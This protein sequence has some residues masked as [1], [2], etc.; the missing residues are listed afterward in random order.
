MFDIGFSEMIVIAVVALVVIGPERLPKVARTLGHL[1]GR[2]Q[3]YVND[4][5]SDIS[6]E[7]ELE[8]LR[9]LQA[10]VEDAARA[11]ET[12]VN[13]EVS[14]TESE[15]NKVAAEASVSAELQSITAPA[16]AELATEAAPVTESVAVA[17][18][19]A[20]PVVAAA[21]EAIA[22]AVAAPQLELGLEP[23]PAS[24]TTQKQA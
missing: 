16:A 22:P 24:S 20:E 6:R 18:P 4:V 23:P 17:A 10:T 3:R 19:V 9:K 21:P 15:L 5:K 11:I 8:E 2:M 7:M 13:Q 1:F 14:S 12:S